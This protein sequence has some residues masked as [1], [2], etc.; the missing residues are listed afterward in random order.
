M[1]NSAGVIGNLMYF[2]VHQHYKVVSD[3][4]R[5]ISVL[6]LPYHFKYD[7]SNSTAIVSSP[8]SVVLYFKDATV[9]NTYHVSHQ[10]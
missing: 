3:P 8:H 9:D 7:E 1:K 4:S 6:Y 2:N 5:N 10:V